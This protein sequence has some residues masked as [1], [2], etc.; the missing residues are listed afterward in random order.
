MEGN[1][2]GC[3]LRRNGKEK[4]IGGTNFGGFMTNVQVSTY[5]NKFDYTTVPEFSIH[6]FRMFICRLNDI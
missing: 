6:N 1:F 5:K 3:K 4:I 2:G